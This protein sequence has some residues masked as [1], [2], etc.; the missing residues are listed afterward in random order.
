MKQ[1]NESRKECPRYGV[2][3]AKYRS[4]VEPAYTSN[5]M[6]SIV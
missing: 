3:P 5:I 4:D 6:V 1:L 2:E